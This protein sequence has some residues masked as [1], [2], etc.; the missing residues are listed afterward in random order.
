MVYRE[1]NNSHIADTI[2]FIKIKPIL[3]DNVHILEGSIFKH[4]GLSITRE[5][6]DQTTDIIAR[7]YYEH[8]YSN[9]LKTG[10][11]Y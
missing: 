3:N 11:L 4:V 5:N 9:V 7:L 6:Q 8:I 2:V 1:K 10:N